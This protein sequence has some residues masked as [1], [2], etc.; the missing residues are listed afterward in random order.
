MALQK[1]EAGNMLN[2]LKH[3]AQDYN[4]ELIKNIIFK[5]LQNLREL[6]CVGFIHRDIKP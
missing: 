5:I 6:H 4:E 2:Y 3:H 1:A